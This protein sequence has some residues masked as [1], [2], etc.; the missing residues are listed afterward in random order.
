MQKRPLLS[1]TITRHWQ[2]ERGE[3]RQESCDQS[4]TSSILITLNPPHFSSPPALFEEPVILKSGSLGCQVSLRQQ[5]VRCG[6]QPLGISRRPRYR[7]LL[8]FQ[9]CA[10]AFCRPPGQLA[11]PLQRIPNTLTAITETL[12][13]VCLYF[14][15]EKQKRKET[16]TDLLC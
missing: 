1:N 13:C 7:L 16:K 12:Q 3:N 11:L 4:L 5:Q 15:Q 10:G 8:V 2:D 9:R 14:W 6:F